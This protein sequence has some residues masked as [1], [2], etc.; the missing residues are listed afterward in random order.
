MKVLA[1]LINVCILFVF[2]AGS[3]YS[4]TRF[5]TGFDDTISRQKAAAGLLRPA[6]PS[7]PA[8]AHPPLS[9]VPRAPEPAAPRDGQFFYNGPGNSG[10]HFLWRE[11]ESAAFYT[12]RIS[13][14]ADL[15]QPLF[16]ETVCGNS[17]ILPPAAAAMLP[18]TVFYWGVMQTDIEG[19]SS[20]YSPPRSFRAGLWQ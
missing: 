20:P 12:I 4:Y 18:E 8:S 17:Y 9:G 11:A 7:P 10:V 15:R 5:K 6:P 1:A 13:A 14:R 16:K 19:E 3:V 2:F